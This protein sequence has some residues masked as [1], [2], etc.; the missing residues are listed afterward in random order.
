MPAW[1]ETK[2]GKLT[3]DCRVSSSYADVLVALFS[4]VVAARDDVNLLTGHLVHQTIFFG[5]SARPVTR[6]VVTQGLGFSDASERL[7]RDGSD[8]A[9][10]A[11][12]NFLVVRPPT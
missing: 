8:Q 2:S 5:D 6:E 7:G 4:I 12:E 9:V 10:N 1:S 11:L 3:E